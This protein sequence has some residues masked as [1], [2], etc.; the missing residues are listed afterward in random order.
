MAEIIFSIATATALER[1]AA[2]LIKTSAPLSEVESQIESV[3]RELGQI[4]A[5]LG[6]VER[7]E[8]EGQVE[9]INEWTQAKA[10]ALEAEDV[11]ETFMIKSVKRKR[12]RSIFLWIERHK[13]DKK[14]KLIRKQLADI[15]YKGKDRVR[16]NTDH[17]VETSSEVNVVLPAEVTLAQVVEKFREILDQNLLP[18]PKVKKIVEQVR[19][20]L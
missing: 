7:Q 16:R 11:L 14:L 3:E 19:H 18:S 8:E 17:A 10:L 2:L 1:I 9:D 20:E 4:H 6:H 15:T 13:V 12:R 5:L